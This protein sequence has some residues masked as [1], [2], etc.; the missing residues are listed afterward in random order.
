MVWIDCVHL[1][2]YVFSWGEKHCPS[3]NYRGIGPQH[4]LHFKNDETRQP[5]TFICIRAG[6]LCL[7][8]RETLARAGLKQKLHLKIIKH[9]SISK[10][11]VSPAC[12]VQMSNVSMVKLLSERTS[13]V[14]P[15]ISGPAWPQE[16]GVF[17]IL[18]LLGVAWVWPM[19]R[20]V[21]GFDLQYRLPPKVTFYS[22]KHKKW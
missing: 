3:P 13:G 9:A 2:K 18:A 19:S 14:P 8:G 12:H 1:V 6:M 20:F 5:L 11:K 16:P 7:A 22:Q 21:G 17:K 4:R 15:V 10:F